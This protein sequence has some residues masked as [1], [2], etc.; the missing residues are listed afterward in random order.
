[1]RT[2]YSLVYRQ[3]V[4]ATGER[5]AER[6]SGGYATLCGCADPVRSPSRLVRPSSS[7]LHSGLEYKPAASCLR[8]YDDRKAETMETVT[9]VEEGRCKER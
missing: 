6:G 5:L 8:R 1:M 3:S 7:T 4:A 2:R 9:E